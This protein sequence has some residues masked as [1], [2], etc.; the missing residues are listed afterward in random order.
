M[1]IS[2]TSPVLCAHSPC[3]EIQPQSLIR[4]DFVAKL[5][6]NPYETASLTTGNE[7]QQKR[8]DFEL[9]I[10]WI[11]LFRFKAPLGAF[12]GLGWYNILR[13]GLKRF[14][15]DLEGK[16]GVS[17]KKVSHGMRNNR[18]RFPAKGLTGLTELTKLTSFSETWKKG[19]FAIYIKTL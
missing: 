6:L 3:F 16:F 12:L 5:R 18:N 8:W 9:K 1:L 19:G 7:A 2:V 15:G 10:L 11:L 13:R 17:A 4:G 14:W